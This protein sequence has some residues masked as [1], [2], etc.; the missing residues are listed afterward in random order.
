MAISRDYSRLSPV[1]Q[2]YL[3]IFSRLVRSVRQTGH[4]ASGVIP[5][6]KAI[7][8][9]AFICC[10]RRAQHSAHLGQEGSYNLPKLSL[11]ENIWDDVCT[12]DTAN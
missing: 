10:S 4:N 3:H 9:P 6:I 7:S 5:V 1:F 11:T 8:L 12:E 2:R